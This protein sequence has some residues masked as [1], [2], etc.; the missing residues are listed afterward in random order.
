M[1]NIIGQ[2]LYMQLSRPIK[3]ISAWLIK[4]LLLHLH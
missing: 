4:L 3:E 1:I 2:P